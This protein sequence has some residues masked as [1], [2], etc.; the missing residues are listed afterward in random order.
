MHSPSFL[1]LDSF[2]LSLGFLILFQCCISFLMFL[3]Y[4]SLLPLIC[5]GWYFCCEWM[6]GEHFSQPMVTPCL[7]GLMW[8]QK[9]NCWDSSGALGGGFS[10][11]VWSCCKGQGRNWE[12]GHIWGH[13]AVPALESFLSVS[14]HLQCAGNSLTLW[15]SGAC[16]L[17]VHILWHFQ[18]H[19]SGVFPPKCFCVAGRELS[20]E[21][22]RCGCFGAQPSYTSAMLFCSYF[23][24]H[25]WVWAVLVPPWLCD[26][27]GWTFPTLDWMNSKLCKQPCKVEVASAFA[28]F[29]H[30]QWCWELT[31]L[32]KELF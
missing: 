23:I 15:S 20:S 27:F 28:A 21:T 25:W 4:C 30:L 22:Q 18:A 8:K 31:L 2:L 1:S 12:F 7:R 14:L 6:F 17:F 16:C 26:D 19:P 13:A 9:V 5:L 29:I 24:F 11:M 32:C 3:C 10:L